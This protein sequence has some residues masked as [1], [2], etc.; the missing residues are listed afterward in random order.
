MGF[1]LFVVKDN[2]PIIMRDGYWVKK[3]AVMFLSSKHKVKTQEDGF[4]LIELLV[5]IL[6]IGI[7]A[8]VAIPVFLNQRQKAGQAAVVSD[9]KNAGMLIEGSGKFTGS[10]PADF[11]ASKGVTMTAMRTSDRNNQL[12]GSQFVDGSSGSWGIFIR[13][14]SGGAATTKVFTSPTDGYKSMNYRRLTTTAGT[15]AIMGQN[16]NITLPEKGKKGDTYTVGIAMRHNYTG[17]RTIYLEFKDN[18]GAW[19]GGIAP[20]QACWNKDEWKYFEA[21]GTM[22]GDGSDYVY[23]SMFG[24][25]STGNTQDASGAVMVKGATIN[26]EA[27][28]DTSGNDFCLLARH[29]NNP[30]DLWHYSSL[31]GG[32]SRGG[33]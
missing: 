22:T 9:L 17:C 1:P 12:A 31:D 19:P 29:E 10:L 33:C 6:I 23:L 16:V 20:T 8:A 7:L 25:M 30:N 4:T 3:K 2:N 27:A 15:D 24:P 18:A 14:D 11:K 21:S 5:V 13:P 32:I 28:L 26:S